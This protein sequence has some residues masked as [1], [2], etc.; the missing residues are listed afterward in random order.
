MN[1]PIL[2]KNSRVMSELKSSLYVE[3]NK[4]RDGIHVSD[5]NLCLREVVFRKIKP[6]IANV[7]I[8]HPLW[9]SDLSRRTRR[10][11]DRFNLCRYYRN[12][13]LYHVK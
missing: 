13:L 11:F 4:E 12:I 8:I 10:I 5:I 3:F 1:K 9:M 6:S 2:I 7:N